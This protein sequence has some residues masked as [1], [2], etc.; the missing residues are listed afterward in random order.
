M[1]QTTRFFQKDMKRSGDKRKEWN[2][3]AMWGGG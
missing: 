1:T 3:N 2:K